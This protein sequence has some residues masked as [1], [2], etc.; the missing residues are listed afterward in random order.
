MFF[1]SGGIKLILPGGP[2]NT[3]GTGS[4]SIAS[5]TPGP[6]TIGQFRK[7]MCGLWRYDD[8]AAWEVSWGFYTGTQVTRP[9]L[10]LVASS[11]GAQLSLSSSAR[12]SLVSPLGMFQRG[13]CEAVG[14]RVAAFNQSAITGVGLTAASGFFTSTVGVAFADTNAL[15][16]DPNISRT[17]TTTANS[18]CGHSGAAVYATRNGGFHL[19]MRFGATQLPNNP[20]LISGMGMASPTAAS[21]PSAIVQDAA[22][23]GKDSTDA[24]IQLI[25][26]D[27]SGVSTKIDTG[28]QLLINKLYESSVWCDQAGDVFGLLVNYDDQTLCFNHSTTH[29]PTLANGMTDNGIISLNG[30]DTGTAVIMR[31]GSVYSR[32]GV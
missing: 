24:N 10:G 2:S 1:L 8:G 3:P 27:N 20:R 7:G 4:V 21:E 12:V 28:M 19:S 5:A 11:T 32:T 23:Y 15:T 30:T 9:V 31:T 13:R 6:L 26:S 22:Y 29:L 17:S 25:T 16:R 14:A 18:Q